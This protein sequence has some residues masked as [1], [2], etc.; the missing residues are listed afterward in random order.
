MGIGVLIA[1]AI[2]CALVVGLIAAG[3][4]GRGLYE[5]HVARQVVKRLCEE[6]VMCAELAE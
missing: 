6:G 2:C 1:A 4:F 5:D 3:W